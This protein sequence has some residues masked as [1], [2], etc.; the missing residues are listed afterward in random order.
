MSSLK[1][2]AP[3]Q[4]GRR[5][6]L[7]DEREYATCPHS[8]TVI[9]RMPAGHVHHARE[10]C[11]DCGVSLRWLPK[12]ATLVRQRLNAFKLARL[13]MCGRLTPW[14]GHF[15][16]SVSQCRKVSPKQQEIIDRL[17]ASYLEQAA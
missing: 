9:E 1:K 7:S 5:R 13:A 16:R 17:S 10:V 6:E 11:A 8:A 3:L 14:E 12:P 2:R 4:E 15:V